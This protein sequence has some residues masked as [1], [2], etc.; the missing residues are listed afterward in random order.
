[1]RAV[2]LPR[3][4]LAVVFVAAV[5]GLAAV[6]EPNAYPSYDYAFV[7]ASAQDVLEGRATGYEV[8]VYSPVPHPLTLL[9]A[10]AAVP[11]G[12]A[13]FA[14]VA[15]L[16]LA[17]LGLL[18]WAL[19]RIGAL[20]GSW[21]AG[22]LAA[23][24]VF[25][26]PPIF[27]LAARNFGDVGFAAL[28]AVAVA[29]ELA[30]P[31]RG[32]V[33]LALLALAGLLRPEAWLLAGVYW[34]YL[35]PGRAWPE[36]LRLAALVASAPLAWM[37]MDGLLTGNPLHS[38][39][40]TRVYTEKAAA[41]ASLDE[42]WI[43][44][45]SV[46]GW[47][48]VLGALAGAAL[49]WHD[50][51]RGVAVPLLAG[52]VALLATVAPSLLGESPVLRRYLVLPGAMIAVLFALCALGWTGARRATAAWTAGGLTLAALAILVLANDRVRAWDNHRRDQEERVALIDH[53]QHWATAPAQ[54][55]YLASPACHPI[56]VPGYGYRPS[57]RYWLNVPARAVAF[58][59]RHATPERGTVLLP[60]PVDRY[61]RRM[62]A[63]VGRT[64]RSNVL[65]EHEFAERFRV[66]ARTSRW[67]LYAGPGCRRAAADVV[68]EAHEQRSQPVG[69]ARAE[70]Q[71]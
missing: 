17:A 51:R 47:P 45:T 33:V 43:A 29:A 21:P 53:L 68:A 12:E 7:L 62:L 69:D 22:L 28:V 3:P 25:T 30:R 37:A 61:Q 63:T 13:A 65:A 70:R 42:A 57:L 23:A 19:L 18:C 8:P 6:L 16:G 50:G 49:A 66:V 38:V 20:L 27:E 4:A 5:A 36:R 52:A 34:L 60:T 1:S 2:S 11:F 9:A 40:V 41:T 31:R 55:A 67:E 56:R 32:P 26:S 54:R 71:R 59:F 48:L 15:A 64:T 24:L 35:L 10:L 14:I 44:I 58:H 46:S 39:E